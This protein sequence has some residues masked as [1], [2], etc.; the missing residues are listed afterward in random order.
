M[1]F[2]FAFILRFQFKLKPELKSRYYNLPENCSRSGAVKKN[3]ILSGYALYK[4]Y[5]NGKGRKKHKFV[6]ERTCL[7]T[8]LHLVLA[9]MI[10]T[11]PKKINKKIFFFVQSTRA[12]YPSFNEKKVSHFTILLKICKFLKGTRVQGMKHTIFTIGTLFNLKKLQCFLDII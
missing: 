4:Q 6:I 10:K 1:F 11:Y 8:S 12:N 3:Y 2:I 7:V 9:K 5:F